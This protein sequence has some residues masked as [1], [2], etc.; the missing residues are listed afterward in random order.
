M[1]DED[2]KCEQCGNDCKY[3]LCELHLELNHKHYFCSDGCE[4]R[5]M[6]AELVRR[7]SLLN[8]IRIHSRSEYARELARQALDTDHKP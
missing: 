1:T 6:R 3:R 5:W 4:A 7:G 8:K 2:R